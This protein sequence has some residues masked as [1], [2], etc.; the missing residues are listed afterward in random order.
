M[1][2]SVSFELTILN[3]ISLQISGSLNPLPQKY[4]SGKNTD[5]IMAVKVSLLSNIS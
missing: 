3:V 4:V 2:N 5:E 1:V